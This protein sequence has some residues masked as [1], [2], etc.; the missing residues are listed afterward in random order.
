MPRTLYFVNFVSDFYG[1]GKL[2]IAMFNVSLW[3]TCTWKKEDL[4]TVPYLGNDKAGGRL[5]LTILKKNYS[6]V[7]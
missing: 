4:P 7:F 2:I 3:K 1:L 6:I 5:I